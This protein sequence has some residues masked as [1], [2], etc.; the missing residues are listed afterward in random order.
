MEQHPEVIANGVQRASGEVTP[1]NA[2]DAI[3]AVAD[4]YPGPIPSSWRARMG[5][6]AKQLLDDGFDPPTVCAALF[7]AVRRARPDLAESFAV[8]IQQARTGVLWNWAEYR[9]F[10]AGMARQANPELDTIHQALEEYFA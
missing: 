6:S 2:G 1:F 10:L 5:K 4:M 9:A 8:E 7:V 3:A